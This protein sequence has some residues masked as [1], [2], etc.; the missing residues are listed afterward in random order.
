VSAV[1]DEK[2]LG[3]RVEAGSCDFQDYYLLADLLRRA[4]RYEEIP[5]LWEKAL[6]QPLTDLVRGKVL[7][8]Q[9][10]ALCT[11]AEDEQCLAQKALDLLSEQPEDPEVLYYRGQALALRALRARN[12]GNGSGIEEGRCAFD[13]LMRS[14]EHNHDA[15]QLACAYHWAAIL[16]NGLLED[17]ERAATLCGKY[18]QMELGGRHRRNCLTELADALRAL[19]RFPEAQQRFEEAARCGDQDPAWEGRLRLQR[20]LLQREM[21]QIAEARKSL[22]SALEFI[23]GHS[24]WYDQPAYLC[25][26]FFNLAELSYDEHDL[27]GA[28]S[29]YEEIGALLPE[30]DPWH[31]SALVWLGRCTFEL[32]DYDRA[33][34]CYQSAVDWLGASEDLKA[35]ALLGLAITLVWL[36]TRDNDQAKYPQAA[37]AFEEY[38]TRH[39][40]DDSDRHYALLGLAGCHTS[41]AESCYSQVLASPNASE[42]D[43]RKARDDL[44]SV[45]LNGAQGLFDAGNYKDAAVAFEAYLAAHPEDDSQRNIALLWLGDCYT[46]IG[47]PDRALHC[48][49]AVAASAAALPGQVDCAEERLRKFHNSAAWLH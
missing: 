41:R 5:D 35:A 38:L 8:E 33:L 17:P 28:A 9:A 2:E 20:G 23:E 34:E 21:G 3:S 43:R 26:I 47:N 13:C 45:K 14:I 30:S 27:K 31:W 44:K 15:E 19:K 11:S 24:G 22:A 25:T 32:E 42:G 18:S 48:Y 7:V 1:L 29:C 46:N 36:A 39:P 37:A 40:Q 4:G 10:E 12:L 6:R 49:R 16:C